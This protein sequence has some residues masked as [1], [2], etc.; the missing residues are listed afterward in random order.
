M[1]TKLVLAAALP[2]SFDGA[3]YAIVW[4]WTGRES[5]VENSDSIGER[6]LGVWI[7][8]TLPSVRF[9]TGVNGPG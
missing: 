9:V 5:G 7:A 3:R 6:K 1:R 2:S 4:R 8:I